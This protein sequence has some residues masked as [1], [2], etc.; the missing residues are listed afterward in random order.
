MGK[1][2]GG[3]G[4]D[5][6]YMK[7][8]IKKTLK[9]AGALKGEAG[10]SAYEIAK[11]N[12]FE[13]TEAEWL[14]NLKAVIGDEEFNT[15]LTA[16]LAENPETEFLNVKK[17]GA[18][19]D[20]TTDDSVCFAEGVAGYVVNDGIYCVD[21]TTMA[22][23]NSKNCIG[24]GY[25]KL[26]NPQQ[27]GNDGT[28]KWYAPFDYTIA[29]KDLDNVLQKQMVSKG[30]ANY[31]ASLNRQNATAMLKP[32]EGECYA[33][34][35][36][37]IYKIQGAVLPDKF[38][39]CIGNLQ[40]YLVGSDML[41]KRIRVDKNLKTGHFGFFELPW[42][43]ETSRSVISDKYKVFDDHTEFYLTSEDFD[44]H[45]DG[46]TESVLH[47][48]GGE[49]DIGNRDDIIGVICCFDFWVKEEEARDKLIVQIGV[50]QMMY[51]DIAMIRAINYDIV[52][53]LN[54]KRYYYSYGSANGNIECDDLPPF[55]DI[56]KARAC[57]WNDEE[58][59][60]DEGRY[61]E[62]LAEIEQAKADAEAEAE[63]LA[64]IPNNEELNSMVLIAMEGLAEVMV[65]MEEVVEP[66]T[67]LAKLLS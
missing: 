46:K 49:A 11:R 16:Y 67:E 27:W 45:A 5:I 37:A 26:L 9:G 25:L 38:T 54:G 6:G 30:E 35:I 57:W 4:M 64:S 31:F 2:I 65:T 14:E 20:G 13:G 40:L 19:G 33:H 63:R 1:G 15:R 53:S 36:G 8:C 55:Q 60:F 12:G 61:A 51:A 43:P 3:V 39:V 42:V 50:D 24:N 22:R 23:L 21:A 48:W 10:A 52:N 59:V 32:L 34:T 29:V 7:S 58:W 17:T 47:F 56:N 62:I 28:E 44:G 18:K 66:L 41:L